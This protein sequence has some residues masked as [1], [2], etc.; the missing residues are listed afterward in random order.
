MS[1]ASSATFSYKNIS[2]QDLQTRLG[3]STP[4]VLIDVRTNSEYQTVHIPGTLLIPLDKLDAASLSEYST[5]D[6][7]LVCQSGM[8][9]ERAAKQLSQAGCAN[10][11]VLQQGTKAWIQCGFPVERGPINSSTCNRWVALAFGLI[12]LGESALFL[13]GYHQMIYAVAITG[14]LLALTGIIGLWAR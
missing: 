6:I 3:G 8:R 7:V 5:S 9:A 4:P 14:V 11:L 1:K 13:A 2:A 12:L 10:L